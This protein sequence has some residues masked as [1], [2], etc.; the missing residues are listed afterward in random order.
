MT[1]SSN[2]YPH[3]QAYLEEK[4]PYYLEMLRQMVAINS[5]TANAAGINALGELTAERFATLGFTAEFVPSAVAGYG[6]HLVLTRPGQSGRTVSLVSHLDTV[7]PP[8]EETHN[9]FAWREAGDRIFGPGTV[10]IKG[11]TVMI[12][13]ILD[14]LQTFA[15]AVYDD[16]TWLILLDAAEEADAED[17]G[18]LCR[19]RLAGPH[20]LAALIFEGG[21]KERNEFWLVRARKGM[22]IC[23]VAVEGKASHAGAFHQNGANAIVQ[24]ADVIQQLAAL[25]DYE[26]EVT[27]NVGTVTGGTVTN[28][29]PHYAEAL[30]EMRAFSAEIYDE[31]LAAILALNGRSTVQSAGGYPCQVSVELLRKTE[32]WPRNEGTD[33]LL[34]LWQETAEALGYRVVPEERGGL[35]DG[36]HFWHVAPS[37]DGLGPAGGNAH[38]SEQSADGSKEQEYVRRSSFVPKTMI[39]TAAILKL[40]E[41]SR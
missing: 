23:R 27:V 5:F 25:T 40:I 28:R 11:G 20:T 39:N 32:P 30:L 37:L 16:I 13:M 15:P 22:A 3:M 1:N 29:V 12:Y 35:S 21:Y 8:E 4:M 31:T 6:R 2:F 33:R 41:Q 10:D 9:Q 18:A 14:A 17:F 38:C 36:N 7:F 19:A 26:R 24:L 34:A